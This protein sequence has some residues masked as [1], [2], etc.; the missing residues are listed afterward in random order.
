[1]DVERS[2]TDEKA[3]RR[4]P[5]PQA[6]PKI[7]TQVAGL[8]DVLHGGLPR[9]RTTLLIGGP[10]AGKTLLSIETLYRAARSGRPA[11]FI[12]FEESAAAIRTNAL[13]MGWDLASLEQEGHLSLLD[14]E[15]DFRAIR[16]GEFNISG[17]LATAQGEAER[18]EASLVVID[19]IDVLMR[20]FTDPVRREDELYA[21]HAWLIKRQFTSILTVKSR[22]GQGGESVFP[23]LDFLMDC[24]IVLDQRVVKQVATRRLR[25]LKYRGSGYID[26]D[27]PVVIASSGMVMMPVSSAEL[28]HEPL[29]PPRSSGH[30]SLDQLLDGGYRQGSVVLVAGPTG[31]GKT[32][33]AC[34]FTLSAARRGERTLY[35][36]FEEG[37]QGIFS[38][39]RGVGLDLSPFVQEGVVEILTAMPESMGVEAHLLRILRAIERFEPRHVVV[40]AI[41][42]SRRMGPEAWAFDFLVRLLGM[43][44]ERGITC[45]YLNQ[46]PGGSTADYLSGFGISSLI[47]TAVVVDYAWEA[48]VL[49]RYLFILKSRGARHSR[50]RHRLTIS[51]NGIAVGPGPSGTAGEGRSQ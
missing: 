48:D 1:M 12:S 32:T 49:E 29:G 44:R 10:G 33:I 26:N 38:A 31:C 19:A 11:L 21:L 46:T 7:P 43:C 9:D 24:I 5:S 2:K 42:A 30:K 13:S 50:K 22:A 39:M 34:T 35:V 6:L 20:L 4:G 41:S 40:D 18:I 14:P 25:V 28:R 16:A 23:F 3:A 47:D 51:N 37:E 27:C 15:L 8:D 36:S 17:L 45:F